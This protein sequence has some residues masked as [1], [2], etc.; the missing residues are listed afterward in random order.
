MPSFTKS[1]TVVCPGTIDDTMKEAQNTIR[2]L[3]R[4]G[5]LQVLLYRFG[6][7]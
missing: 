3:N 7:L 5:I 2:S 6:V 1:L 4:E